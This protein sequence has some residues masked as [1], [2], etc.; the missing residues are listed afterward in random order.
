MTH[1]YTRDQSIDGRQ[2]RRILRAHKITFTYISIVHDCSSRQRE[3]RCVFYI[4]FVLS[5]SPTVW[6]IVFK[7]NDEN[8]QSVE[9]TNTRQR[10]VIYC[11]CCPLVQS[12]V[13]NLC[14]FKDASFVPLMRFNFRLYLILS[15]VV[16]CISF[17]QHGNHNSNYSL[18]YINCKHTRPWKRVN[19]RVFRRDACC[20][21]VYACAQNEFSCQLLLLLNSE[22]L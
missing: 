9:A 5:L 15:Y 3:A 6:K 22:D 17:Y 12:F 19:M 2:I 20:A 21:C 18:N 14:V 1:R 8:I 7:L 13:S 11:H 4:R 10:S 16:L